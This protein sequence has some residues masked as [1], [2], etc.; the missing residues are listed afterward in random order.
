MFEGFRHHEAGGGLLG[1][2]VFKGNK[3]GKE[4]FIGAESSKFL[5]YSKH[6][7]KC[8]PS[9]LLLQIGG[10][11]IYCLPLLFRQEEIWR[12]YREGVE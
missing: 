3:G 4:V 1:I 7:K 11:R 10:C 6:T 2:A 5:S 9:F 8:T 12:H